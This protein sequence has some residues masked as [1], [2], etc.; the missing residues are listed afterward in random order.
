MCAAISN[1]MTASRRCVPGPRWSIPAAR[2]EAWNTFPPFALTGV[3]KEGL[4]PFDQKLAL[5]L[6]HNGWQKELHWNRYTLAGLGMSV[7]QPR[8]NHAHLKIHQH[9]QHRQ[10]V[11][12]RSIC[13]W[14]ASI[15]RETNSS[16]YW[17]I[18]HNGSWH[19]EIADQDGHL[20]LQLSGPTENQSH[21]WEK[22]E[23]RRNLYHR[24]RL[25]R[26]LPRRL[27]RGHGPADRLPPRH[28]PENRDN[29]TLAVIF[30][31]YM[32]CLW[33]DPTTEKELPLIDKAAEAGCEY[34]S[35]DAGWYSDGFWWDNVGEWKPAEGRFPGG[36][37]E[38]MDYIRKKG[39]VPGV[40]LE[41]EVMG[42]K[43]PLADQVPREWYF[44]RHGEKVYDRSRY[45]LD[46]RHPG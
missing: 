1:F 29:E 43:C 31:D 38:V 30:N 19:W 41:I 2:P 45:Q 42:I 46:F 21:W 4:L 25:R 34:Y 13:P 40:W 17:Q 44:L 24:S 33:A 22:P 37:K 23:A 35:V 3:E 28:P 11:H 5:Y 32:N 12:Q 16:L 20:Y 26:L 7:S 27:R 39:M 18:E 9:L 36:L 6:P 8:R 15:I 10:L 14:A